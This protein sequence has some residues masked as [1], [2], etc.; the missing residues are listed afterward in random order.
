MDD[1][2]VPLAQRQDLSPPAAHDDDPI[3]RIIRGL[4]RLAGYV[5]LAAAAG[6]VLFFLLR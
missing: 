5:A 4:S 1:P 2:I 3:E 6:G